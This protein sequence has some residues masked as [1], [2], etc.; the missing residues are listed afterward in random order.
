L[1]GYKNGPKKSSQQRCFFAAQAF[2]AQS[3]ESCG[4]E[5]FAGLPYR[6]NTLQCKKFLCSAQHTGR[7]LSPL[8]PEA[9][10]LT[11]FQK[12]PLISVWPETFK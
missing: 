6:F 7:Q 8:S 11:G 3:R 4:L 12:L 9:Y 1:S 10:L 5:S 2:H